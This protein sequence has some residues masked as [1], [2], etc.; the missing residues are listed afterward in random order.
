L[1]QTDQLALG[2]DDDTHRFR[3]LGIL[4]RSLHHV[5]LGADV[6]DAGGLVQRGLGAED[7]RHLVH[8]VEMLEPAE[9][10]SRRA[11]EGRGAG[12]N[13]AFVDIGKERRQRRLR[14]L[15]EGEDVGLERLAV[16][17]RRRDLPCRGHR[18]SSRFMWARSM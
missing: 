4:E 16:A 10:L 9:A 7:E 12:H 11:A 6:N 14:V 15:D 18:V 3:A 8:R 5:Q 2:N 13:G 1:S 17:G